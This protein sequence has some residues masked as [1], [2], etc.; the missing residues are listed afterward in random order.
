MNALRVVPGY[1]NLY[2]HNNGNYY[3]RMQVHRKIIQMSLKVKCLETAKM[4]YTE[5]LRHYVMLKLGGEKYVPISEKNKK[6]DRMK[7]ETALAEWINSV[8]IKGRSDSTLIGKQKAREFFLKTTA[9][10]IDEFSQDHMDQIY[11]QFNET[12]A[13]QNS[14]RSY[15]IQIKSFLNYCIKKGYYS[16]ESKS[17]IDFKI[18]KI[19]KKDGR[20]MIKQDDYQVLLKSFEYDKVWQMFLKTLWETGMRPNSEALSLKRSDIDFENNTIRV[21]QPKVDLNKEVGVDPLFMEELKKYCALEAPQPDS[22]LFKGK[23]H[24]GKQ[25][26]NYI[27]N[28]FRKIANRLGLSK[29]YTTYGFRHSFANRVYDLTQNK[30]LVARQLGHTSLAHTD[31]YMHTQSTDD[32]KLIAEA[33]AKNR[34]QKQK[35]GTTRVKKTKLKK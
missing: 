15:Q 29:T 24:R 27:Q 2:R 16:T 22:Y 11:A 20:S 9:R 14:Q 10:Y 25:N 19:K 6:K 8:K 12:N 18:I 4:L 26:D 32:A 30:D 7:M 13:A 31:L 34:I 5:Y 33:I 3:L 21:Y 35:K 28:N 1:S 23:K 17:K